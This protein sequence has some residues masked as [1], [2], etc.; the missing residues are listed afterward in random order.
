MPAGQGT[1]QNQARTHFPLQKEKASAARAEAGAEVQ[2]SPAA[3]A[4]LKALGELHDG[5]GL[6]CSTRADTSRDT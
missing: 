4:G 3:P 6:L 1:Q 5:A 2:G